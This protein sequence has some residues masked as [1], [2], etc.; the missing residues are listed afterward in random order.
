MPLI[1][2]RIIPWGSLG[3]SSR[4]LCGLGWGSA[5]ELTSRFC[6]LS[7][8]ASRVKDLPL[9][10]L[11]LRM[12]FCTRRTRWWGKVRLGVGCII[13]ITLVAL[14]LACSLAMFFEDIRSKRRLME[15]AA[16]RLSIRRYLATICASYCRHR[17]ASIL[18]L[19]ISTPVLW[20]DLVAQL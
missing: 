19:G 8:A 12:V 7:V 3:Y 6:V 20:Q 18:D 15:I 10:P 11:L 1:V 2:V 17:R 13:H 5:S 16:D 4:S 9:R 14:T